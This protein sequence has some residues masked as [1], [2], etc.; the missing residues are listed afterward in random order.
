MASLDIDRNGLVL[1]S[2]SKKP[3]KDYIMKIVSFS[4]LKS[5]D[6]Y[7]SGEFEIE[8]YKWKLVLFPSGNKK[9]NVNDHI[10][11]YLEMGGQKAIETGSIVTVDYKFFLLNRQKEKKTYLVLEDANKKE[12][13]YCFYRTIVGGLAGFDRFISIEDFTDAFNG[14]L[15]DDTCEFG[16]DVFVSKS[17]RKGKGERVSMNLNTIMYKHT[18]KVTDFSKLDTPSCSQPFT[19]ADQKYCTWKLVLYP[20][21]LG[22]GKGSH[23]SVFLHVYEPETQLPIGSKILAEYTIRIMDQIHA[24]HRSIKGKKWFSAPFWSWGHYQFITQEANA[25]C[26]KNDSC[27]LEVEICILGISIPGISTS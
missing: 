11:L 26:L 7:E 2:V 21:G 9:H 14:Y 15:I 5:E 3:P 4:S 19:A 24:K 25:A 22:I 27:I 12:K 16:A 18:W 17:R 6:R 10:S 23:L 20:R 8:G 13:K 1:R